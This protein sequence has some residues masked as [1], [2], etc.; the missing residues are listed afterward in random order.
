MRARDRLPVR[1]L[2]GPLPLPFFPRMSQVDPIECV[3]SKET[4]FLVHNPPD[5]KASTPFCYID[6]FVWKE[7]HAGFRIG[8]H[9][10]NNYNDFLQLADST[11]KEAEPKGA[12]AHSEASLSKA[13]KV[14]ASM[15]IYKNPSESKAALVMNNNRNIMCWSGQD[16]ELL[17][18]RA[19]NVFEHPEWGPEQ[20]K[21]FVLRTRSH[22][23]YQSSSIHP[24]NPSEYTFQPYDSKGSVPR[25]DLVEDER[26]KGL[27]V[28]HDEHKSK[29]KPLRLQVSSDRLGI[30]IVTN[31]FFKPGHSQKVSNHIQTVICLWIPQA[32]S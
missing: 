26:Y 4:G 9:Q 15:K 19:P 28:T 27:F 5:I 32:A 2:V 8:P 6:V 10:R 30:Q 16:A 13:S 18:I 31:K 20:T 1:A 29:I 12:G 17:S 14:L 21:C 22:N 24:Y 23:T 25:E 3:L 7:I 11:I